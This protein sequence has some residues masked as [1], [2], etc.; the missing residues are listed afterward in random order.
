MKREAIHHTKMRRLAR[1]LS[2]QIWGARGIMES[3]WH[4]AKEE[5]PAGDI[6]KLSNEDIAD[7]VGWTDDA[8]RL[9]QAL[10]RAGWLDE[11]PEYRLLVHDWSDHAED[12]VHAKLARLKMLFASGAVPKINKLAEQ[13]RRSLSTADFIMPPAAERANSAADGSQNRNSG[14]YRSRESSDAGLAARLKPNQTVV[15]LTTPHPTTAAASRQ[16]DTETNGGFSEFLGIFLAAGK[17]LNERDNDKALESW[18]RFE[19][20]E[21]D[22]IL[23]HLKRAVSDGTWSDAKHTPFPASYLASEA[24]RRRGPGRLLPSPRTK[25]EMAQQEAAR[26]FMEK[27]K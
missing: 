5:A 2:V 27:D 20:A 18:L 25:G 9:V 26:R 11:N 14:A 23:A 19:P 3:L 6:G 24:W 13:E 16:P 22:I 4:M 7:W 8:D 10:V 12:S 15:N 17:L 21:H 1:Y